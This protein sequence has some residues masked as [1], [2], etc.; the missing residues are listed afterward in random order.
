MWLQ[1][2]HGTE[3]DP[4][5]DVR[6]SPFPVAVAAEANAHAALVAGSSISPHDTL[7]SLYSSLLARRYCLE[8]GGLVA[9]SAERKGTGS[10]FT[11]RT[12]AHLVLEAALGASA[13][14]A[15]LPRILD[16][17]MGT[18][19][20]LV[21]AVRCLADR[22]ARPSSLIAER[23]VYGAD[24]D[25]LAVEL[26]V[27]SVHLETGARIDVLRRHLHC[28]DMIKG[29]T[30]S[31]GEWDVVVGNPPWGVR[32]PPAQR[33]TLQARWPESTRRSFDS[34]KLFLDLGSAVTRGSLG[35]I[36]PQAMLAQSK[37]ADVRDVLLKRMVPCAATR[38]KDGVF[39]QAAAPAC[40]LVFGRKA[41]PRTVARLEVSTV[42]AASSQTIPAAYWSAERFTLDDPGPLQLL[43]RLQHRHPTFG[44]LGALYRIRD[45]GLNYNRAAVAQRI[46]YSETEPEDPRDL[47]RYRGR[48]FDRY[49]DVH[50]GG[51]LRH[52]ARDLLMPGEVLSGD[53][54]TYRLPEKIVL[55]QTADCIVATLDRSRMAMGRSVMAITAESQVSLR[56]LL[57][58][59]NSR[60]ITLLYRALSG[61]EGRILPQVKAG[62]LKQLPVPSI[63]ALTLED[64]RTASP[65]AAGPEAAWRRLHGLVERLLSAEGQDLAAIPQIDRIVYDLYGLCPAEVSLVE[66]R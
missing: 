22:T 46:F 8:H 66:A 6:N 35:M 5:L 18:G 62:T 20:F 45:V 21:E 32:Y 3:I 27:L 17:A 33:R 26:A 23:C 1:R 37:H 4:W 10:F 57:A 19:V 60:L 56:A 65:V 47:A 16:P 48:N 55:R 34:F 52:N 25:P 64:M 29:D 41:A 51:W 31:E 14:R 59:L 58:L 28:A 50:H 36:V 7:T 61:E 54:S 11:P 12:I 44:S 30:K 2:Q 63:C 9:C 15:D 38:L 49:T 24:I 43:R 39:P 53:W 42:P 40:V 13:S